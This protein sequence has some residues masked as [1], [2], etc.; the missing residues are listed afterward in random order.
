MWLGLLSCWLLAGEPRASRSAV[1][2]CPRCR[3]DLASIHQATVALHARR[4][5]DRDQAARRLAE[6]RWQCHPEVVAALVATLHD[7]GKAKVRAEAAEALGSLVPNVPASHV[8]LDTAARSDPD[9][10]VRKQAHKA[11]AA[12]GLRCVTDCPLCGP[13]PRGAAITGP[14]LVWPELDRSRQPARVDAE[15]TKAAAGLPPALPDALPQR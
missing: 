6:V 2:R 3:A 14:T 1:E 11:L 15:T 5:R 4:W 13:L 7:D 9:A 10:S 12:K 8:A